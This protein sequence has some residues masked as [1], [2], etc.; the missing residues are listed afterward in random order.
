MAKIVPK[1]PVSW[2]T[3]TNWLSMGGNTLV[4]SSACD[5]VSPRST[6]R[7]RRAHNMRSRVVE[8]LAAASAKAKRKSAPAR[9]WLAIRWQNSVTAA[10]F[11]GRNTRTLSQVGK[12]QTR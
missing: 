7:L 5:S 1:R 6:E 9:T 10:G 4:W 8:A 2:P 11:K 3:T 12:D